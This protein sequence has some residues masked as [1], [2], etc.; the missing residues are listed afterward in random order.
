MTIA[1]IST[2]A[3]LFQYWILQYEINISTF[4]KLLGAIA[5]NSLKKVQLC[6]RKTWMHKHVMNE[7]TISVPT[8]HDHDRD[9]TTR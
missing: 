4:L 1:T 6:D 7:R 2:T 9:S 3:H 5:L 8:S